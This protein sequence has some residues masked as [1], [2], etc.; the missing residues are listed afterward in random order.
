MVGEESS[1]VGCVL[2]YFCWYVVNDNVIETLLLIHTHI[3]NTL[4]NIPD[5]LRGCVLKTFPVTYIRSG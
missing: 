1:D 2:W 3:K 5:R 4:R